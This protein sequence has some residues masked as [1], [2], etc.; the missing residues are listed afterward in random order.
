MKSP[1]LLLVISL[2]T[3]AYGPQVVCARAESATETPLAG[4]LHVRNELTNSRIRFKQEGQG[5]VA[6]MGGSITEMD[7]FRPR[8]MEW[9]TNRFADTDF[10]F[11]NAGIASTGST[12]GAFR[13]KSDILDKQREVDLL[14]LEFAVNDDQDEQLDREEC[15]RAMEGIIRHCRRANP[16]MDI[17]LIHFVNPP[18]LESLRNGKRPIPIRCHETVAERYGVSSINLAAVVAEKINQGELRWEDYGGTHPGRRGNA[19]CADLVARLLTEAW[20]RPLTS[21]VKP[22]T[23]SLPDKI[24]PFCYSQGRMVAPGKAD[25]DGHWE[26]GDPDWTS[27]KGSTRPRFRGRTMLHATHPGAKLE[28][29]FSG[30]AVGVYVTAGPDAGMLEGR[31]DDSSFSRVNLYHRFSRQ[32]HYPRTVMLATELPPGRHRLTLR[33]ADETESDGHAARILGFA[34]NGSPASNQ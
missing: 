18:M 17:V 5:H 20:Q 26:L 4:H 31:I 6:F 2:V 30:T 1:I 22:L 28:L 14:F 23:H 15:L 19:L 33:I 21:E 24:D 9:L 11:T 32:L 29:E 27:L 8:V 25:A 13:L 34:V 12:T 10:R 3:A 16:L 7:G